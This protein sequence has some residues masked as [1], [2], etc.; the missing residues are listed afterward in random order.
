MEEYRKV[1]AKVS[2]LELCKTPTL[3]AE[4]TITAVERLG[5]DA[6][7]IFSDLLLMVEPLGIHLEFRKNEGPVL[8]NPIRN[9][10][11]L[12][13]LRE[14][15]VESLSFVFDAIRETR[16]GLKSHIPLIG[17][18][19]APF[20]LASY[21]IEGG[22]SRNYEHTKTLMYRDPGAWHAL[23]ELLSR[24][25]VKYLNRQIQAGAQAVQIFDSWVGCLSPA[26]YREFV[27]P[28]TR[29]VIQGIIT[30]IPVIHFG[31][32]TAA[33]LELMREAG[34]DVIG[35]DYRVE[36][37]QAWER[38]GNVGIQGNLDPCVLFAERQVIVAKAQRILD[39]ARGRSGHIFNLGHGILPST[40]V[41]N[42]VALIDF[43]HQ[44]RKT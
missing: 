43:V 2:L 3:A 17:F 25:L 44:H 23:M 16:T 9:A 37:D 27:L 8:H 15:E 32:S 41:D 21:I 28:H 19:G 14:I 11:D 18:A 33:L 26:D 36:L 38:L 20:T 13:R 40:P 42:V 31:T 1:R 22:S 39:Q 34:G 7:I 12:K 4:A 24:G 5:V 29:A 30:G 6:A 35:V 10:H